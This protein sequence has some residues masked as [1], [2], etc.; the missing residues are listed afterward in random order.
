LDD[1]TAATIEPRDAFYPLPETS[2]TTLREYKRR[3]LMAIRTAGGPTG[4]QDRQEE[5]Y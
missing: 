2:T 4:R 1:S 3:N 5:K